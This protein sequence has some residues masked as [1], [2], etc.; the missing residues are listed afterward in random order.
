MRVCLTCAVALIGLTFGYGQVKQEWLRGFDGQQTTSIVPTSDGG[1]VALVEKNG[2]TFTIARMATDGQIVWSR[3]EWVTHSSAEAPY[4][5]L[6]RGPNG[7]CYA[8]LRGTFTGS[9]G[10]GVLIVRYGDDGSEIWRRIYDLGGD[11]SSS[12]DLFYDGF[13]D[14]EGNL[15]LTGSRSLGSVA[16]GPFVVKYTAAGSIAYAVTPVMA[17]VAGKSITVDSEGSAYVATST[18]NSLLTQTSGAMAISP[19]GLLD[20]SVKVSSDSAD[21]R[22]GQIGLTPDG[23]CILA[24]AT[25]D[26]TGK[27]RVMLAR[28]TGTGATSYFMQLPGLWLPNPDSYLGMVQ[29]DIRIFL[30]GTDVGANGD[31]QTGF[32]TAMA[33]DGTRIW[34]SSIRVGHGTSLLGIALDADSQIYVTGQTTLGDATSRSIFATKYRASGERLWSTQVATTRM[35]SVYKFAPVVMSPDNTILVGGPDWSSSPSSFVAKHSGLSSRFQVEVDL[36]VQNYSI[37]KDVVGNLDLMVLG[38]SATGTEGYA[39]QRGRNIITPLSAPGSFDLQI[40]VPQGSWLKRHLHAALADQTEIS[41]TLP[42]GDATRDGKVN[43]FDLSMEFI[44]FG[45]SDPSADIDGDGAVTL[46]DLNSVF[47]NFGMVADD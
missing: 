35:Q 46:A 13:V 2:T 12:K 20:W 5:K 47:Q 29:T 14:A 42:N 24:G 41:A 21:Q 44:L 39:L 43:L 31:V 32:V 33:L 36:D 34:T 10:Y 9:V 26:L 17:G 30:A 4:S 45:S 19:G 6:Y 11:P 25:I 18:T 40:T 7:S 15:Y 28:L 16:F 38:G 27:W 1:A 37:G 8:V 3:D 22:V 23:G